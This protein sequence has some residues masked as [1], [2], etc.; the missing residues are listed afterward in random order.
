[1]SDTSESILGS[2]KAAI[3][4]VPDYTFFDDQLIMHINTVFSELT[5]LGVGPEDGFEITGS[6]ET[7]SSYLVGNK[8]LNQVKTLVVLKVRNMFDPPSS[9]FAIESAN[10][11]I[12][13]LVG[14]IKV[15]VDPERGA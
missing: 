7:W 13:E 11:I 14:R 6:D 9:S 15:A 5:Q 2:V 12:D 4:I 8:L 10:K 3:G 1:M